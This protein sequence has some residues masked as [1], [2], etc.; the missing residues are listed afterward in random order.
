MA[1][2]QASNKAWIALNGVLLRFL[3]VSTIDVIQKMHLPQNQ[4]GMC[5]SSSTW[6]STYVFHAH[7]HYCQ[8]V[9]LGLQGNWICSHD[10]LS[11]LSWV[12]QTSCQ[13]C[14]YSSLSR[15]SKRSSHDALGII[16]DGFE[17]LSC[18]ASRNKLAI[19]SDQ[20]CLSFNSDKYCN[21]RSRCAMQ[22]WWLRNWS[23][24]LHS[25]AHSLRLRA[26]HRN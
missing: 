22:T 1:G 18:M 24:K 11:I 23:A 17:F 21:S 3:A 4:N 26:C 7:F 16:A 8:M 14:R 9:S 5:R 20:S 2:Y 15:L 12:F 25:Q 19:L 10:I 13:N 6:F